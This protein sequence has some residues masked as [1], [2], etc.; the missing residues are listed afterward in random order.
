MRILIK[1]KRIV[2]TGIN[3][4]LGKHI[5]NRLKLENE[6]IG[7]N[8]KNKKINSQSSD[9]TVIEGDIADKN[10]LSRINTDID[11]IFHF[12]S[13]TSIVLF[14]KD[15]V[16][17][18]NN[19]INGMENILEYAKKNSIKKLIYPSSASVYANNSPPHIENIIPKPAN[20]Y[21]EAKIE[22]ENLAKK[23]EESVNSLG[24][25]IFAAYGPGEETKQ[26]LSSVIN[27]FLD[28][29]LKNKTPIIFGDGNQTRD[30]I[31]IED[32]IDAILNATDLSDHGIINVGSGV[33]TSFNEIIEK[34]SSQTGKKITPEYIKKESAYI[35]NL[36]ADTK[37][38]KSLLKINPI[39]ID[40]GIKK[41]LKYLEI[42][43]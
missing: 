8:Q 7:I 36:K 12:G 20:K 6:I 26:N 43:K 3:G 34:I 16:G 33:S 24:L 21:G 4:F 23:Y 32:V 10:T 13:P 29:V 35:E 37:L 19:T 25:R 30:F 2:I 38:M 17:Y 31:Y 1:N 42:I 27:L 9:Y 11:Y 14:K 40:D 22:S 28:D 41:F 15:P 18:F 5:A 39:S